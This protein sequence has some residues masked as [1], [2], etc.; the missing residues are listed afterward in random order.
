MIWLLPMLSPP[1]V[2]PVGRIAPLLPVLLI[3]LLLRP[4]GPAES[5]KAPVPAG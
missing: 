4:A 3:V 5:V 2:F 1:L